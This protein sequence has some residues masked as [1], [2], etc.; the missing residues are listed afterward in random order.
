MSG[1]SV[2]AQ[3]RISNRGA[4][5]INGLVLDVKAS[6]GWSVDSA[7]VPLGSIEG[8]GQRSFTIRVRVGPESFPA[9]T[10]VARSND[11]ITL[12]FPVSVPVASRVTTELIKMEGE[13]IGSLLDIATQ[14]GTYTVFQIGNILFPSIQSGIVDQTGLQQIIEGYFVKRYLSDHADLASL[15]SSTSEQFS[16]LISDFDLMRRIANQGYSFSVSFASYTVT[17]TTTLYYF[18]TWQIPFSQWTLGLVQDRSVADLIAWAVRQFAGLSVYA[19]DITQLASFLIRDAVSSLRSYISGIRGLSEVI[20]RVISSGVPDLNSLTQVVRS[21]GQ[22]LNEL[23]NAA[24]V[25]NSLMGSA[26]QRLIGWVRQFQ[27]FLYQ[28]FQSLVDWISRNIPLVAGAINNAIIWLYNTLNSALNYVI[29][30][31]DSGTRAQGMTLSANSG[32]SDMSGSV[33][34]SATDAWSKLYAR[35]Q[36]VAGQKKQEFD[37]FCIKYVPA[38]GHIQSITRWLGK[39]AIYGSALFTGGTATAVVASAIGGAILLENTIEVGCSISLSGTVDL[40]R[41]ISL[42]SGALFLLG[43]MFPAEESQFHAI[44]NLLYDLTLAIPI[45]KQLLT[46]MAA[47]GLDLNQ[48]AAAVSAYDSASRQGSS[49]YGLPSPDYVGALGA[50]ASLTSLPILNAINLVLENIQACASVLE[51]FARYTQEGMV[52]SDLQTQIQECQA[53]SQAAISRIAGSDYSAID[54]ATAL[55]PLASQLNEAIDARYQQ[56]TQAKQIL[57]DL[58]AA[59]VS[60]HSCS[61]LWVQPDPRQVSQLDQVLQQAQAE[62]STGRYSNAIATASSII[63]QATEVSKTC[64][65]SANQAKLQ[66]AAG[67]AVATIAAFSG[68]AFL[69]KRRGLAQGTNGSSPAQ[70]ATT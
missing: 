11:H 3:F 48:I 36:Q 46:S 43:D 22:V 16:K 32:L 69:R 47:S 50:I 17:Y 2:Q 59:V 66:V 44:G 8:G 52:A 31:F 15:L 34:N 62:F 5:A 65:E 25:I 37:A 70:E 20:S 14:W 42:A 63:D 28:I 24:N 30:I 19:D 27:Q 39:A 41:A 18:L 55:L 67:A 10:F 61:F 51:K 40:V 57:G 23:A 54:L 6:Q 38:L 9:I 45:A 58:N 49:A 1:E 64:Q 35:L 7:L 56:F 21:T 33:E 29:G 4:D 13:N 12:A 60:L 26:I 68:F 53:K